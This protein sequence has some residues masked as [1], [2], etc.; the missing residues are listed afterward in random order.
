MTPKTSR[1]LLTCISAYALIIAAL[2]LLNR[3]GPERWWFSAMNLYLPQVFWLIPGVILTA[4]CL[5]SVR[6]WTWVPLLC[7]GWVAGPIMGFCWSTH[8]SQQTT[9]NAS[10]RIMTWNSKYGLHG[11]LA[12]R[13]LEYDID[14]YRPD[15]LLF[16]DANG[17][18]DGTLGRYFQKWHTYTDSQFVIASR[19]PL[20]GV[21][22]RSLKLP[23]EQM[24]CLRC[25]VRIGPTV[26]TVYNVHLESPRHGL[27]AIR[28]ARKQPWYLPKAIQQLEGNVYPRLTQARILRDFILRERG[29]VIVAG[30]LNSPDSSLVC[31]ELRDVGL[32]DAFAEGGRGYGYTYGHFLLK[33]RLP[34]LR[35]SWMRIDHILMSSQF[36]TVRAWT[37]TGEASDHR[38]VIADIFLKQP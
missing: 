16:Q 14:E 30:D 3:L 23:W 36:E 20:T 11:N 28:A 34:R 32:H 25:Q 6:R 8:G 18:L 24:T 38:P 5:V 12:H 19:F 33:N 27:N 4:I 2:T 26:I 1:F 37:G 15:I 35:I 17:L 29:P 7:V 22:V 9:G 10:L 13:A 31:A 21:E